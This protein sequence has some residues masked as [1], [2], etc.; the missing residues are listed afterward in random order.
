[1]YFYKTIALE[2]QTLLKE[3][4]PN[5][6]GCLN[7]K[8]WSWIWT[9]L[10]CWGF[11]HFI[12]QFSNSYEPWQGTQS[13]SGL[14]LFRLIMN[15]AMTNSMAVLFHMLAM[16]LGHQHQVIWCRRASF[17]FGLKYDSYNEPKFTRYLA[18]HVSHFTTS[19]TMHR[20]QRSCVFCTVQE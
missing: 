8:N 6:E 9:T 12:W 14:K 11:S 1:M 16:L 7:F 3:K 5:T 19:S 13:S 4:V 20:I 2:T 10:K 18:F 15:M 17:V